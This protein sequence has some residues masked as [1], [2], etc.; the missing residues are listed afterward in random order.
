MRKT[1]LLLLLSAIVSVSSVLAQSPPQNARTA[2][3]QQVRAV[4]VDAH[5]RQG[6]DM[7]LTLQARP[8]KG[9]PVYYTPLTLPTNREV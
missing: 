4:S 1:P 7:S 5:V 6:L 3:V 2:A 8:A 9:T